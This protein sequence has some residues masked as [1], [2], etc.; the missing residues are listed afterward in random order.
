MSLYEGIEH[1]RNIPFDWET[2]N[3]C[4]FVKDLVSRQGVDVDIQI[5]VLAGP[6]EAMEWL[7]GEGHGSLYHLLCDLFGEPVSP[8]QAR[9][10]DILYRADPDPAI[11]IADRGGW[12]LGD[13]GLIHLSLKRCK[14]AFHIG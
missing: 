6:L 1:W 3:C 12:F 14:W 8:L 10:G 9:R 5:P 13:N 11:G 4:H 7:R 2:A